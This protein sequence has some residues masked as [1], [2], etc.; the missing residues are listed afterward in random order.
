M[1]KPKSKGKAKC[2]DCN[3]LGL[4]YDRT[5]FRGWYGCVRCHGSGIKPKSRKR[6]GK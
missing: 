4:I 2:R 5:A 6:G 1:T 3:G